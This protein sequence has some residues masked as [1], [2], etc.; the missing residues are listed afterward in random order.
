MVYGRRYFSLTTIG[1]QLFAIGGEGEYTGAVLHSSVEVFT[2]GEGWREDPKLDMGVAKQ[3]LCSVALGSWL[4]TI[5]GIVDEKSVKDISNMVEAYDTSST[6]TTWLRKANMIEQRY[7]HGCHTGVFLDKEGIFVAG[8]SDDYGDYLDTAEF[9]FATSDTWQTVGSLNVAR[10]YFPM[11]LVGSNV[12]VSGGRNPAFLTSVETWNGSNWVELN[13][14]K[15]GRKAHAA[16]S[17][18]AGKLK[19]RTEE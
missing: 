10:R 15:M 6:S 14:L 18:E 2:E 19:C 1:D 9:Y 13:E 8:G 3:H 5:G 17:F 11:T 12:V 7:G 4:Y 16:V